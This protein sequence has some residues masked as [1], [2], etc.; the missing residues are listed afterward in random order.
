MSRVA[1]GSVNCF[2]T[3]SRTC[4][5]ERIS[6]FGGDL[7]LSPMPFSIIGTA[8]ATSAAYGPSYLGFWLSHAET[9]ERRPTP[10]VAALRVA[11]ALISKPRDFQIPVDDR[12]SEKQC[13]QR[14]R[15]KKDA[16]R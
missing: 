3:N 9:S 7:N 10:I 12:V 14:G 11:R 6:T 4:A 1:C 15:R 13:D 16:E 2:S 5:F 8:C